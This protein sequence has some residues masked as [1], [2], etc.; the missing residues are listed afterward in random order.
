MHEVHDTNTQSNRVMKKVML[1][2]YPPTGNLTPLD[3]LQSDRRC[4]ICLE[5]IL[6]GIQCAVCMSEETPLCFCTVY[7]FQILAFCSWSVSSSRRG[8]IHAAIYKPGQRNAT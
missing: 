8:E 2:S 5:T 3:H 6:V 4:T 1:T 7:S